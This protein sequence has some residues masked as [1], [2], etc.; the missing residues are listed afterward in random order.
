MVVELRTSVEAPSCTD[1]LAPWY[2]AVWVYT[3]SSSCG[4]NGTAAWEC[5]YT[6]GW[7]KHCTL[8]GKHFGILVFPPFWGCSDKFA[9]EHFDNALVALTC[10]LL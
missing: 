7:R 10:S 1:S 9:L 4:P 2:T 6:V 8:R 3:D 5:C